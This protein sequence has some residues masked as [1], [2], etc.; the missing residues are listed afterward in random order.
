MRT[1]V[2]WMVTMA[3]E[4]RRAVPGKIV[5]LLLLAACLAAPVMAGTHYLDGSPVLNAYINGSSEFAPGTDIQIPVI[6]ENNGISTS[7]QVAPNIIDLDAIPATAK[8]VTVGMSAGDAPLVIKSDPQMIGDLPGQA[9]GRVIVNATVNADAR[10]GTYSVPLDIGYTR[11]E[12]TSQYGVDETLYYYASDHVT[13]TVPIT[14]KSE[15]IPQVQTAVSNGVAAGGSGYLNLTVK[16]IGSLDGSNA[17][18]MILRYPGSPVVPVDTSAYVGEFPAG[19]TVS[20]QYKVAAEKTAQD[21]TYPVR[22]AVTYRNEEGDTV[23]TRPE[24]VGVNV[25]NKADFIIVSP[26]PVIHPGSRN[27]IPVEYRNTGDATV[28]SAR[29]RITI[30]DPFTSASDV[31]D[32]GDLAPGQS[33][34]AVF[35][36]SVTSDATIKTYGL[37]SDIRYLDALDTTHVSDPVMVPVKVE[38]LKGPAAILSNTLYL[39]I[40]AVVVLAGG[41]AAWSRQKKKLRR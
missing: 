13:L 21:K 12:A 19:S 8:F 20:C 22:V 30:A 1:G 10:G 14:V 32:L 4:G 5:I 41:I 27:T 9:R 11:L 29:A 26:L 31:A 38:N 6:I 7:I 17:T 40:I 35:E 24:T 39:S 37:V 18:V 23:T 34:T 25:G 28:R 33:A 15:V 36:L 3:F 2:A 16:N